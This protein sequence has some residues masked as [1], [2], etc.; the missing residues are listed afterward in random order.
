MCLSVL[1]SARGGG[2][3]GGTLWCGSSHQPSPLSASASTPCSVL[4]V[5]TTLGRV[6]PS[7]ASRCA[8]MRST[9]FRSAWYSTS[10]SASFQITSSPAS[11]HS[12]PSIT[13]TPGVVA[14]MSALRLRTR[15]CIHQT[16][17]RRT[18]TLCSLCR[19]DSRTSKSSG[20]PST[21]LTASNGTFLSPAPIADDS[22]EWP[23]GRSALPGTARM[24]GLVDHQNQVGSSA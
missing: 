11:L 8:G 17:F 15:H 10:F 9:K 12:W 5:S 16:P 19:C 14:G 3:G 22:L 20:S 1:R 4:G 13:V 18:E 6:R 2:G 21:S 7:F 23:P 24:F